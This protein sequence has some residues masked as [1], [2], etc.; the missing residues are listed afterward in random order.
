VSTCLQ[1]TVQNSSQHKLVHVTHEAASVSYTIAQHGS[2]ITDDLH[3]LT[4]SIQY[5]W[6][7]QASRHIR[8]VNVCKYLFRV[9][10]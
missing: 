2:M 7:S 4:V 1:T 6:V 3:S 8:I 9:A 5:F 10:H